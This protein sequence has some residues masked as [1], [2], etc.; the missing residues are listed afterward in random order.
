M[1]SLERRAVDV[2]KAFVSDSGLKTRMSLRFLHFSD[3]TYRELIAEVRRLW[4]E[5]DYAGLSMTLTGILPI[6]LNAQDKL[7]ATQCW[8]FLII[9]AVITLSLFAIFK[10]FRITLLSLAAN[11][12]PL[13]ME[14]P[15]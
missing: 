5:A 3:Q 15:A 10:S 6:I 1:R 4:N 8:A 11:V 13:V 2:R 9:L 7:L 14:S 12:M